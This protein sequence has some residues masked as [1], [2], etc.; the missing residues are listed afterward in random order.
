M[1]N[2][3]HMNQSADLYKRHRFPASI[4]Q[5]AVWLYHRFNLSHRD[6]ED[7]LAERGIEVSYESVRLW[8]NKFGPEFSKR[9]RRNHPGFG[10]TFFIDEVFVTITGRRHYLWR[11]VDQDGDVIDVYL[12]TRRDAK[13]AKRFFRRLLRSF[14][15]K[16]W[17]IGTDRLRSYGV[18][19]RELMPSTIHDTD[20]YA[21]NRAEL[22][23]QPTRVRER[24][25]RGFSSPE[26]AQRFLG[27]HAVVCSLFNLQRHLAEFYRLRRARAFKCWDE[28]VA[29]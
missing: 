4:I 3:P 19:H 29:A 23:H 20:H 2:H 7:L 18:A 10:D 9:L 25:M 8:C 16:P 28:A 26:Q 11:A 17:K 22:S 24:G 5:Y 6:I 13:A 14:G 21:N 27:V 1:S 12:Q 15:K